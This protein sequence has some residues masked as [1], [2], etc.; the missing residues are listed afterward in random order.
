MMFTGMTHEQIM[1]AIGGVAEV[2]ISCALLAAAQTPSQVALC[3]A[4][5]LCG[6]A[7][8]ALAWED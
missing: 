1:V 8:F 7:A 3:G 5:M 4:A 2:L 6:F